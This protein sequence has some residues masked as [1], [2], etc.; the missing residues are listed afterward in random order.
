M[1]DVGGALL[2]GLA[3][4]NLRFVRMERLFARLFRVQSSS[5]YGLKG[6]L[7]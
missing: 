5:F 4:F 2:V 7:E 3:P 6:R 1:A